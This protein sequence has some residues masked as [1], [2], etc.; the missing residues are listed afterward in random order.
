MHT[1]LQCIFNI[2]SALLLHNCSFFRYNHNL[3]VSERL[4]F[5]R[6]LLRDGQL[7]LCA[8]QAKQIWTCLAENAVRIWEGGTLGCLLHKSS[9]FIIT[10]SYSL[11]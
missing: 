4:N 7:W 8:P 1:F 6:F 5:L 11:A 9:K 10:F 2:Y 3:Q